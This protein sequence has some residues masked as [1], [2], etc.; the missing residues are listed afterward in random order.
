MALSP[1]SRL[2]LASTL[3][4]FMAAC[5]DRSQSWPGAGQATSAAEEPMMVAVTPVDAEPMREA[6]PIG[7]QGS[8]VDPRLE[9]RLNKLEHNVDG[10][11]ANVAGLESDVAHLQTD[12]TEAKPR[13]EKIDAMERHFGKLSLELDRINAK[14]GMADAPIAAPAPV[15]KAPQPAAKPK[16]VTA[17]KSEPVNLVS[18]KALP[19]V[20]VSKARPAEKASS[21]KAAKLAVQ[22]VRIGDQASG[23]VR[24]VLDTTAPAK[25]SYDLDN[26]EKLLVLEVPNAEWL[27]QKSLSLKNSPLVSSVKAEGDGQTSRLIVQLK[28]EAKV[29]GSAALPPDKSGGHRVYLDL[30]KK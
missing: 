9:Q 25:L 1:L 28:N 11:G 22:K 27:A 4:L 29:L 19:P 2:T 3:V 14:Y 18:A 13:L 26:T 8:M 16:S 5:A 10:L 12:M 24:I 20:E 23:N 30:G 7:N 6:V 17:K 21:A 15:H